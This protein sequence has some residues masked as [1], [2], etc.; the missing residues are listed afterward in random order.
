MTMASLSR[1]DTTVATAEESLS[2]G[3]LICTYQ[4]PTD[5]ERCLAGLTAQTRQADDIVVVCR[6]SD[7]ATRAWLEERTPD[8]LPLRI[9][10]VTR[11]GIVAARN[12]GHDACRTDI[13]SSIDDDVVPHGDWL[14]RVEL[15]FLSDP[16][17]GALGGRDHV[18]NGEQ[19]DERLAKTVGRLQWFGRPIGNHH[20][21]YGR[22]RDVQFLK[23]ANMSFRAKAMT[24]VRFDTRLCGR[25]IEAHEDLAFSFAVWRN[26]WKLVY[27]PAVLVYHYAGRPDKRAYSSIS[28]D[29]A[30]TEIYD[31]A[32]N[33]VIALWHGLSPVQRAAFVI[34]SF[35]IG[36]G[37]EPGLL[38]AI[39]YS[40]QLGFQSLRRFASAQRGRWAAYRQIM[41][42]TSARTRHQVMVRRAVGAELSMSLR[43]EE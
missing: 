12:A 22:P 15:H 29:V 8:C 33:M 40:K 3:V 26:G 16:A 5:L 7:A 25:K 11:P 4:R 34:W 41:A 32:F 37:V 38:Q 18:H 14:R 28:R 24:A 23:G 27:D 9:V 43:M 21:G 20:L 36:T 13:L 17:L 6:D 31:V 39:R 2:L 35:L 10:T 19:F 30:A 1:S 42:R